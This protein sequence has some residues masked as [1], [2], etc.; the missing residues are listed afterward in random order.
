MRN[1]Y[2]ENWTLPE[3]SAPPDHTISNLHLYGEV[4]ALNNFFKINNPDIHYGALI[5]LPTGEEHRCEVVAF[6]NGGNEDEIFCIGNDPNKKIAERK[7]K[8]IVCPP[9]TKIYRIELKNHSHEKY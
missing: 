2:R 8:L 5:Q 6:A 3:M 9:G 7:K 1:G 4:K